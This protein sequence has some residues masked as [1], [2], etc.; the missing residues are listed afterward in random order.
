MIAAA[1]HLA[2]DSSAKKSGAA[3]RKS[4]IKKTAIEIVDEF[5]DTT[6]DEEADAAAWL[7]KRITAA[8]V[9]TEKAGTDAAAPFGP[10]D[11]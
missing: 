2:P 6:F 11:R 4:S 8:L 5:M 3:R 10:L 7:V 9:E 1:C